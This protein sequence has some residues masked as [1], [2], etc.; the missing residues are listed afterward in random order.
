MRRAATTADLDAFQR[1]GPLPA[2]LP[3]R[4]KSA[5]VQFMVRLPK[6]VREELRRLAAEERRSSSAMA[7]ILIE[8]GIAGAAQLPAVDV[9]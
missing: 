7:A 5:P 8:R 4:R 2:Q 6:H 1:R 3:R 9:P